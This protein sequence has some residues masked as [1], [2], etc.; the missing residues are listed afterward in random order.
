MSRIEGEGVNL[1]LFICGMEESEKSAIF[2][3][4]GPLDFIIDI[5]KLNLSI[6]SDLAK[7]DE[8]SFNVFP[9]V[10]EGGAPSVINIGAICGIPSI[11]GSG[12][13]LDEGVIGINMKS[14]NDDE[15]YT[16]INIAL[17]MPNDEYA[18]ISNRIHTNILANYSEEEY[19]K[20]WQNIISQL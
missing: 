12:I 18:S 10:S 1:K 7:L 14:R 9:S 5:G 4:F 17:N 8:V 11:C 3:A 20:D 6:K 15:L 13:G 2:D 19:L 16:I